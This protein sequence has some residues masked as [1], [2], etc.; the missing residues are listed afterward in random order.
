V[1]D[2][3]GGFAYFGTFSNPSIVV[4][5]RLSDFTR[6][7]AL[8]LNSDEGG[9]YAAVIDPA[10]G[11]AYFLTAPSTGLGFD[12]GVVVKVR[13]SDFTRVGALTLNSGEYLIGQ[14]SA[15]IDPAGD[16][17]Y[18][19]TWSTVVKVRLSDFTR[20]GSLLPQQGSGEYNF[21]RAVI[22]PA[23]GFAYFGTGIAADPPKVVKVRLSDFTEVGS[24]TLNSGEGGYAAVIDPAGGFGYF[25]TTASPG[26]V[27][28]VQLSD[29]TRVG[30]LTLNSGENFILGAAIDPAGG[31][32]YFGTQTSPG[33][34]VRVRLSDFTRVGALT[35]NSGENLLDSAVIDPAKGFAYFGTENNPGIV[36]KIDISTPA[37]LS[38]PMGTNVTV[39][40]NGVT[41][42]YAT[43]TAAGTTTFTPINP[44]SSAGT[45]PTGY[46]IVGDAPAYD[47]TTTATYAPP[48][49]VCFTVSSVND[50]TVFSKL[51]L[52]HGE[53]G[54]LVDRTFRQD[55]SA[56]QICARVSSLSPF[57][58]AMTDTPFQNAQL[59][60]ISTRLRV[61]T[62]ENVLIGGFIITGSDPK[63]VIIRGIGPSLS[64]FFAGVL[65]DPTLDLFQGN[66]LLESNDNWKVRSDGSS[67]QAAVAATGIPPSNDLESAIVR[68]L[69]PGAYTA[70]LRGKGDTPG[71]GVVEAY[72]LNQT[73][74]SKFGDIATRGFVDTNDNVMIGGLIVGPANAASTK[75]V[76]RAIGPSLTNFGIAG[77]LQDPT[78]ELHDSSGTTLAANDNWKTR[79]DGSSQEA[80]IAATG[81]Q[82]SDDRESALV[83][84]LS[85]GGY[86]AIVRGKTNTTGVGLVEVYNLQ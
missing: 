2:P 64:Q 41:V 10:G 28:K 55:F 61:Q 49:D 76:V 69:Q 24:L 25:G 53:N 17:A 5:V 8:T 45:P 82:P 43:V 77:A 18:F 16:F 72:D 32:A 14:A 30:A 50:A 4:K 37:V 83:Q 6:V 66:T 59:L 70:I 19:G 31:F 71:I 39:Q 65:A 33:I 12:P 29:L 34:V 78:L 38:T 40:G 7:G 68:T 47:I 22:D 54:V 1:I 20:V 44:P 11:F 48:I 86:T 81:L 23:G 27:V 9:P 75:V 3:A 52:L 63:N 13:L 73:A 35:L 85:P 56:R 58:L 26:I 51:R 74:N 36:V 80:E 21:Q 62:G 79:P 67:Q 46:T 15:V 84:T 60:N 57:V 42:T